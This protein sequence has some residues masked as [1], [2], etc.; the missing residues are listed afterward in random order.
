VVA[1]L[2]VTGA[3]AQST[4]W[5]EPTDFGNP[6]LPYNLV[7]SPTSCIPEDL[8]F[9]GDYTIEVQTMTDSDG[10]LHVRSTMPHFSVTA[11]GSNGGQYTLSVLSKVVETISDIDGIMGLDTMQIFRL[12]IDGTGPVPNYTPIFMIVHVTA[13]NPNSQSTGLSVTHDF[14]GRCIQ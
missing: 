4:G 6:V 9:T 5:S 13:A 3:W 1:L 2:W 8:L 14:G 10:R 7:A 12:K 11:T